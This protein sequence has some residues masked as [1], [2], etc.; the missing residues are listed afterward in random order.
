M[1]ASIEEQAGSSIGEQVGASIGEQVGASMG[2][3]VGASM[4]EKVG[5]IPTKQDSQP[6]TFTTALTDNHG[7]LTINRSD[8]TTLDNTDDIFQFIQ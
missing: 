7:N 8:V 4:E 1:S 5:A 6:R 2:E 3:Q